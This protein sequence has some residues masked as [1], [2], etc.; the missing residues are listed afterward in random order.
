MNYDIGIFR[1]DFPL[2]SESFISAQANSLNRYNPIFIMKTRKQSINVPYIA[3][4]D[5]DFWN[6]RQRLMALTKSV[7]F[8]ANNQ[9]LKNLKLLHAHFGPDGIYALS[10]AQ[11]LQIP[12][13]VT[14]HGFDI[15]N[16]DA[17][18]LRST[19]VSHKHYLLARKR[20]IKEGAVFIA[21]SNFIKTKLIQKGFPEEKVRQHYIG[22]DINKFTPKRASGV[23]RYILCVGR[24]SQVKGIDTLLYAF[25]KIAAKH[26]SVSLIQVGTGSLTSELY[27]LRDSLGLSNQVTFIGPQPHSI[28]LNLMQ[29]AELFAL[30]CQKSKTGASEALGIVFNEASACG[31]PIISTLHGGIPEAV[32][33]GETG[34][35]SNEGDI[36]HLS[37]SMDFLLS[38]KALCERMGMRGR[39]YA[40]DMFDL[41]KQSSLLE[42]IYAETISCNHQ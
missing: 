1:L 30:P 42:Q 24:H 2:L 4:S 37:E 11:K 32:L 33:H 31:I 40:C 26:P 13:I 5:F 18:F 21:V 35:L 41:Q 20:L 28:V 17:A 15:T 29:G 14:F 34:I 3:L 9:K 7:S 16:N 23:E 36:T 39:E 22:V 19:N 6:I 8:F 38:D 25:A 12:L 10:I 27:A